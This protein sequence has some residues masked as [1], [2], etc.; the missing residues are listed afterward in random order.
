MPI[1]SQFYG[2]IIKMYYN[3]N[4]KH[5]RAHIHT[6]YCEFTAVF[7]LSG[8]LIKRFNADKTKEVNRSLD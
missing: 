6:Q 2:I 7:D 1:I 8:N 5:H 4:E 3:D